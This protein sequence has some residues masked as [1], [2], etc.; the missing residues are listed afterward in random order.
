MLNIT[1]IQHAMQQQG[2]NQSD[3]AT[4]CEVSREAVSRWMAGESVPRPLK[5]KRIANA[6]HL[7]IR[8]LIVTPEQP[9]FEASPIATALPLSRADREAM[10]DSSWRIRELAHL[11]GA[12]CFS[13]MRL[14]NPET[15]EAY[16]QTVLC[17]VKAATS[18]PLAGFH[19]THELI[20]LNIAAGAVLL[21][22]PWLGDRAGQAQPFV[23]QPSAEDETWIAFGLNTDRSSL[24]A[25]LGY[26]LGLQYCRGTLEGSEARDFARK[27]AAVLAADAPPSP[28]DEAAETVAEMYFDGEQDVPAPRFLADCEKVFKTPAYRAIESFQR[29][30]GGRNP[31]FISSMLNVS[32]GDAVAWSYVLFDRSNAATQGQSIV[33][34]G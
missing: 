22:C 12:P 30:E 5:L 19:T 8:N 1:L 13:P 2:L 10:L 17:A 14:R 32:A 9:N 33:T 26:A 31:A 11:V 15:E 27:F 20:D 6:L 29:Q 3:L 25:I 34:L 4:H 16:L 28:P 24:D 21:P 23:I 7:N 18:T